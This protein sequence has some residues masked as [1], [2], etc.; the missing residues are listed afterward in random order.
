MTAFATNS[1]SIS[2]P[3]DEPVHE[4]LISSSKSRHSYSLFPPFNPP[5]LYFS[6]LQSLSYANMLYPSLKKKVY[7]QMLSELSF[8]LYL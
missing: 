6:S 2:T 8:Y 3:Y 1:S 4:T 5:Y 7:G